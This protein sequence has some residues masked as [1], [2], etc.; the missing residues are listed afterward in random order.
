MNVLLVVNENPVS[1]D[2]VRSALSLSDGTDLIVRILFPIALRDLPDLGPLGREWLTN[3]AEHV[4]GKVAGVFRARG[5][6]TEPLARFGESTSSIIIEEAKKFRAGW[7]VLGQRPEESVEVDNTIQCL[8][9]HAP[10]S[11]KVVPIVSWHG[12]L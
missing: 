1:V 3:L 5:L 9:K 12:I 8:S 10:C 7:I 2:L 6:K 11:V 4:A